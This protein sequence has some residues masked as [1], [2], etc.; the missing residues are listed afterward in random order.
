MSANV[1]RVCGYMIVTDFAKIH[2]PLFF[3]FLEQNFGAVIY[4]SVQKKIFFV[5][6]VQ[7]WKLKFLEN[8]SNW[9]H[10]VANMK[11]L[12]LIVS[13]TIHQLVATNFEI[14][15][16]RE[17]YNDTNGDNWKNNKRW[18]QIQSDYSLTIDQLCA[19]AHKPHGVHCGYDRSLLKKNYSYIKELNLQSN[20]LV[21]NIPTS[22]CNITDYN[23]IAAIYLGDNVLQ[24][25]LPKCVLPSIIKYRNNVHIN[26]TK[27]FIFGVSFNNLSGTLSCNYTNQSRKIHSNS[28]DKKYIFLDANN[29][30]GSIP[31]C[32]VNN[33]FYHIGLSNNSLN[34]TLHSNWHVDAFLG[35]VGNKLTGTLPNVLLNSHLE[36]H[37]STLYIDLGNNNLKGTIS[38]EFWHNIYNTLNNNKRKSKYYGYNYYIGL[39]GNKFNY[40]NATNLPKFGNL[41]H[42]SHAGNYLLLHGNH[43]NNSNISQILNGIFANLNVSSGLSLH[44]NERLQG[45]IDYWNVPM[46]SYFNGKYTTPFFTLHN[47]D[48]YGKIKTNK[49]E[50]LLPNLTYV[51][52]YNNHL[53][54]NY[55]SNFITLKH[56]NYNMKNN[57]TLHP[58]VNASYHI[59][60]LFNNLFT[61]HES[62][63]NNKQDALYHDP[64]I[65]VTSAFLTDFDTATGILYLI[66]AG[67]CLISLIFI[68]LCSY[69]SSWYSLCCGNKHK[70]NRK[71][72]LNTQLQFL[73]NDE[74]LTIANQS[75]GKA[76]GNN[77]ERAVR[78]GGGIE[79]GNTIEQF[80]SVVQIMFDIL[81]NPIIL[82]G[83]IGLTVAYIY[84]STYYE[85]G[86]RTSHLSLTYFFPSEQ[87]THFQNLIIQAFILAFYFVYFNF[88]MYCL[89]ANL[90]KN[91]QVDKYNQMYQTNNNNNST[92][93]I[94]SKSVDFD[95]AGGAAVSGTASN[96]QSLSQ[97]LQSS[98]LIDD[99]QKAI[100]LLENDQIAQYF[101]NK[102]RKQETIPVISEYDI[103][104]SN[105]GVKILRFW[106][107]LAVYLLGILASI[108][109]ITIKSLPKDN[110]ITLGKIDFNSLFLSY[111]IDYF[112]ALLLTMINIYIVPKLTDTMIVLF[113]KTSH[114]LKSLFAV[115]YR[116]YLIFIL[117]SLLIIYIPFVA[118]ITLLPKCGNFWTILWKPCVDKN[119]TTLDMVISFDANIYELEHTN[120]IILSSS[121]DICKRPSGLSFLIENNHCIR[122]FLDE[123]SLIIETKLL[124][125]LINPLLL[126]FVQKHGIHHLFGQFC[127]RCLKCICCWFCFCFCCGACGSTDSSSTQNI[128]SNSSQKR[129]YIYIEY[130]YAAIA[131]KLEICVIFSPI[132]PYIVPITC[133][134][135][136]SNKIVYNWIL[137]DKERKWVIVT[138]SN[139][140]HDFDYQMTYTKTKNSRIN[141]F[142]SQFPTFLLFVSAM[143]A[144]SILIIFSY[145]R[146]DYKLVLWYGILSIVFCV[147]Q[148]IYYG[149]IWYYTRFN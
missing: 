114:R 17:L 103:D 115:S 50:P 55:P 67:V 102:V 9:K 34:G 94:H 45:S 91:K 88:I 89:N 51:T 44:D 132:M 18:Q 85:C 125:F 118:S 19:K 13:A 146:F 119:D 29:F 48:I 99:H 147:L 59:M 139:G 76:G 24:G 54:C 74:I 109:Y 57:D 69:T 58:H 27:K 92:Q 127:C 124:I 95:G 75:G 41:E 28:K 65:S 12:C 81:S 87:F 25:T 97:S 110:L 79:S 31:N 30:Q 1:K 7:K 5:K 4:K 68:Q 26:S 145:N 105:I 131:T 133:L 62:D 64:F 128:N 20:N 123:W 82:F 142:S 106:I 70:N 93:K 56:D 66:L 22:I 101:V 149:V 2:S 47:C 36:R 137:S 15:F 21:G 83:L 78:V 43:L 126:Y 113:C 72:R 38:S 144:Q 37:I 143:F 63:A 100:S 11:F 138:K 39:N 130:E 3:D 134:G 98:L 129:N 86:K 49:N 112:V 136:Q 14:E 6:V 104:N 60:I 10:W 53:S 108:F 35:L 42:L 90:N 121:H 8:H 122:N 33:R 61:I 32:L 111:F 96:G 107:F 71:H 84:E 73:S 52:L 120:Q 23:K 16:L 140:K 117:R 80:I 46:P 40:F 77:N 116:S 135:L 141:I 148:C